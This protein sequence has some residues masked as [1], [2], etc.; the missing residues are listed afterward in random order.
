MLL[1]ISLLSSCA[2]YGRRE[3]EV[4][5]WWEN[6]CGPTDLY[7]QKYQDDWY[8]T[9]PGCRAKR[10][11]EEQPDALEVLSVLDEVST[12]FDVNRIPMAEIMSLTDDCAD[13]K[14]PK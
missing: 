9:C 6:P 10:I 13:A 5:S 1:T 8:Y 7:F 11:K 3:A 14:S 2:G 4:H 12:S